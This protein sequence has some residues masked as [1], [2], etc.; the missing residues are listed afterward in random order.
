MEVEEGR[1]APKRHPKGTQKGKR[2]AQTA[3]SREGGGCGAC[4]AQKPARGAVMSSR[5]PSV[6]SQGS[7]SDT[8]CLPMFAQPSPGYG[9]RLH[10]FATGADVESPAQ[11]RISL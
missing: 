10:A 2:P 5:S 9:T 8:W 3:Q 6:G 4:A 11:G 7:C 1:E